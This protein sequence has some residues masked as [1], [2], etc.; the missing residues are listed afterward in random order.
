[1]FSTA[2]VD[3]Y[4]PDMICKAMKINNDDNARKPMQSYMATYRWMCL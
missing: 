1:M 2:E 4:F 3:Y